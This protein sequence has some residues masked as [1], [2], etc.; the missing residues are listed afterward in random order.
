MLGLLQ[1]TTSGVSIDIADL[2]CF[3]TASV[4]A[5]FS[6]AAR[7]LKIDASTISRRIARLEDALGVTLLERGRFG[8]R[9]TGAGRAVSLKIT[10][11]LDDL[12]EIVRI[13]RANG[14]GIEGGIH[15][16]VRMPPV[17]E[18]LRSLLASWH[19]AYPEVM[20]NL[21]ELN[22]HEIK[23][24]LTERRLD[25]AFVTRHTVWPD[26]VT[27]PIYTER[28]EAALPAGHHLSDHECLTW[29]HLR[30]EVFLTQEWPGSHCAREFFAS[31]LGSGVRFC[32]HAASKQ[33]VLALVGAGFGV[34]LTTH[35]QAEARFPGVVFRSINEENAHVQV[36][37][38]WR[39]DAEDP[40]VGRFIAF[41]RDHAR[42]L[43]SDILSPAE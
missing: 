10:R 13:S 30:D 18:P 17:G 27:V 31:L 7:T 34:T 6:F 8:I 21:H 4:C 38:T 29:R 36:D 3:A 16:G 26:A 28:L 25:S 11:T 23:L 5:N 2:R 43:S 41:V 42:L 22:D 19:D 20:L 12:E 37:M 14:T 40:T 24:G 35:S 9:L 1:Q 39:A 32:S 33:S 15:L